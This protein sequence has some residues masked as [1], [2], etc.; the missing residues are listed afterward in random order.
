MKKEERREITKILKRNKN[1][2]LLERNHKLVKLDV[3]TLD[4]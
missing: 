2:N 4:Q 3:D 1:L